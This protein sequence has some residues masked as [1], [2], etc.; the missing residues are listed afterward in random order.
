MEYCQECGSKIKETSKKHEENKIVVGNDTKQKLLK[1]AGILTIIAA[2]LTFFV[3]IIGMLAYANGPD[4]SSAVDHYEYTVYYDYTPA[5]PQYLLISA[6]GMFAFIMGLVSGIL[7][8]TRRLF[9]ITNIGIV[10]IMGAAFLLVVVE[11]W[12]F[13]L[14]GIP[15]LVLATLSMVF[16]AFSK[17]GFVS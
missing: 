7:I 1:A 15:I 2:A 3:V 9:S 10:G 12:F 4:Y 6:F 11:L 8:L 5:S 14:L 17:S 13:V 16:T